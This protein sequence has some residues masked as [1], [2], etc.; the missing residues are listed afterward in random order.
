MTRT[1]TRLSFL[2]AALTLALSCS[3][4]GPTAGGGSDL[5]NGALAVVMGTVSHSDM[6]P[7]SGAS[8]SLCAVTV[9]PS[10]DSLI[11]ERTALTSSSGAFVLDSLAAG[12][13]ALVAELPGPGLAAINQFVEVGDS[14]DTVLIDRLVLAPAVDLL[15][16]LVLPPGCYY[17][18]VVVSVPGLGRRSRVDANHLYVVPRVPQGVYD[19]AITYDSVVNYLRVRVDAR[20]DT[21]AVQLRTV[22][23][24]VMNV[25]GD[26]AHEFHGSTMRYS[27][28]VTPHSYPQGQEPPWYA[29][30]DLS[31]VTY[32]RW[33]GSDT[34]AWAPDTQGTPAAYDTLLAGMIHRDADGNVLLETVGGPE[35]V[36]SGVPPDVVPSEPTYV[37]VAV[38]VRNDGYGLIYEVV[39][40]YPPLLNR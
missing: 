31:K 36:L 8:L 32:Y 22:H 28:A 25:M 16:S 4:S 40:I 34:V 12:R 39:D 14:K 27:Y 11:Q 2:S 19:I 10:G 24:A 18:K 20:G 35:V 7:A 21:G 13:Y 38:R 1:T 33:Q 5:P 37:T 17:S 30:V 6:S 15:G 3:S 26:S 23:F 9:T 29:L